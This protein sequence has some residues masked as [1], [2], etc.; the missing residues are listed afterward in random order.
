[1]GSACRILLMGADSTVDPLLVRLEELES[2]WSRFQPESQVSIMN[3]YAGRPVLVSEDVVLLVSHAVHAWRLT[4]GLYDPTM[5]TEL[6]AHGYDRSHELLAPP[7]GLPLP[8]SSAPERASPA[9]RIEIDVVLGSVTLPKGS[10]FDP[11]G[12]GKGLAADMLMDTVGAAAGVLIDLGGDLR[13]E[14]NWIDGGPWPVGVADP[15]DPG[16]DIASLAIARGGVATSSSLRRRWRGG[17]GFDRH[18][19]LDPRTGRPADT[20]LV[21][22]TVNAG[23]AWFA[24][25]VAKAAVVGGS[26]HARELIGVTHTAGLLIGRSGETEVVGPLEAEILC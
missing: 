13:I 14:G 7:E 8:G 15:F 1:M 20:D 23:T 22:V 18:H 6:E 2:E 10:A 3:A 24:D 19:L 5:L 25:V 16:R 12:I 26:D 4:E 9:D 17:D 21:A 11:G